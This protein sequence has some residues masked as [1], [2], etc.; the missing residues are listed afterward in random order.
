MPSN[1]ISV[2]DIARRSGRSPSFVT[3]RLARCKIVPIEV[4]GGAKT[5]LAV[6]ASD[7]TR[8]LPALAKDPAISAPQ[9]RI[10]PQQIASGV[11]AAASM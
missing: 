4:I 9:D 1:F 10:I 5:I 7:L 2:A 8:L 11:E 6:S 3:A